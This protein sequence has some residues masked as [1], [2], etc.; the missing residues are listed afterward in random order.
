MNA[1]RVSFYVLIFGFLIATGPAFAQLVDADG[2]GHPS[3]ASGGDD[4]DDQDS[5]RYPGNAEVCDV[6]GRDEDCDNSTFGTRD[7]D[8][9][10]FID[11]WC[12]NTWPDGTVEKGNDCKDGGVNARSIH[13]IATEACDGFDN[14]C[15]G[16]VDENVSLTLYEDWDLDGHGNPAAATPRL[17]AGTAGYSSLPNDCDDSNPAIQPGAIVCSGDSA[18]GYSY[19]ASDGQMLTGQVCATGSMCVTQDNGT[20]VCI[21]AKVD[22]GKKK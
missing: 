12:R 20:G 10:G 16:D 11:E 15:D 22:T 19:C 21:P 14:N 1:L 5:M 4:C 3:I 18:D 9:D 17:C 13:P 6:L 7:A 2:D 8:G